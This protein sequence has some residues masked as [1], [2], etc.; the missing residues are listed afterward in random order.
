M[1]AEKKNGR[2]S[3]EGEMVMKEKQVG[4]QDIAIEMK[5]FFS[6]QGKGIEQSPDEGIR[7]AVLSPERGSLAARI[8]RRLAGLAR[9]D[10]EK[11]LL[12]GLSWGNGRGLR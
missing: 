12:R 4:N 10:L 11:A 7:N 8:Q 5:P 6:L 1:K 9:E 2:G 3:L